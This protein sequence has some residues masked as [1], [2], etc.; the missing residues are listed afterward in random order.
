MINKIVSVVI[1]TYN[2]NGSLKRAIDSILNQTYSNI[3]I[4]VVDDNNPK[5]TGRIKTEK[6]MHEYK[7]NY[8]IKYIKHTQNLN[9]AFARNTGIKYSRGEYIC[10]LDDDDFYLPN[11]IQK[12][13]EYLEKNKNYEGVL[14]G[15]GFFK[16]RKLFD[17]K[18][19][20]KCGNLQ[21]D[22]L[23][24]NNFLGTG[25]NIFIKSE[26]IKKLKDFDTRFLRFQ[27]VEFMIRFFDYYDVGCI[28]NIMIIKDSKSFSNVPNYDKMEKM[29]NLFLKKFE[30]TILKYNKED[31]KEIYDK[32]KAILFGCA[33]N[34]KNKK[35]IQLRKHEIKKVRKL[36]LKEKIKSIFFFINF[37]GKT[38][39]IDK[40]SKYSG[41]FLNNDLEY[42]LN[43]KNIKQ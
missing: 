39:R 11:R 22:L 43:I 23:L 32:Y 30:N 40:I 4:L 14:V 28:S 7:D 21:L 18:K 29:V 42:L 41:E 15:V 24:N 27:D 31:Q 1:T 25:S 26:C 9:G 8:K 20:K 2:T 6:I 5:T 35:L 38:I 36:T 13:V 12:S 10:F 3:E 17:I 37:S 34:T 16:K 19:Y 33:L